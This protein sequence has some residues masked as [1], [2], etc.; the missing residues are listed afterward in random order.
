MS[1]TLLILIVLTWVPP[2]TREDGSPLTTDEISHY[3]LSKDGAAYFETAGT[4][5]EVMDKGT[6]TVRAVDS[7][8]QASAESNA[9]TVKANPSAPGQLRKAK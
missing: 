2:E 3:V 5:V 4:Q 7:T 8:G 9:V 1:P 6:Y